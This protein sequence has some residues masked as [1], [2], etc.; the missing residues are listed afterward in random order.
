MSFLNQLKSQASTLQSQQGAQSE[1]REANTL[2]T[3][4]AAK[5]AWLYISELVKQLNVISPLGPVLA[6]DSKKPWPAMKLV[7]FQ[8][9]VR[10][11]KLDD[12]E[13]VDFISMGWRLVP[14]IGP[15]LTGSV[16]AN[17]PPD[18]E[19]IEKRLSAGQVKHERVNVRHPEKNTLKE[20]RFDYQTEARGSIK[21]TADHDNGILMFRL[22]CVEAMEVKNVNVPVAQVQTRLLDELAKLVVRQPSTFG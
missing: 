17:F 7:G 13:V 12:Q 2:V 5:T 20:I 19:R 8:A 22:V 15:L 10:K 9:D 6:L 16:S 11:K 3:E 18:L 21:I 14:A 1:K 4:N